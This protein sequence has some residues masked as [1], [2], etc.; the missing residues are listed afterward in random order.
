M[1]TLRRIFK[2]QWL[3]EKKSPKAVR[4]GRQFRILPNVTE[5][6]R[7]HHH[8]H[9]HRALIMSAYSRRNEQ[10]QIF[11]RQANI[12]RKNLF[13]WDRMLRDP[14]GEDWPTMLGRLNAALVS[15]QSTISNIHFSTESNRK[16][17]WSYRGCI[18]TFRIPAEKKY[19]ECR[20]HPLLFVDEISW[21]SCCYFERR[22]WIEFW[23]CGWSGTIV[24]KLWEFGIG[25][26]VE[27]WEFHD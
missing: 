2:W 11:T 22:E 4:G 25:C 23:Y 15:K 10:Q 21:C 19:S 18:R 13:E 7:S 27:V 14:R 1:S 3:S 6:S 24:A 8:Q 26:Y 5:S 20:W 17:K 16:P 12:L 9:Q